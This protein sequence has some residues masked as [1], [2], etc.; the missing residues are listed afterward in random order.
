M[1]VKCHS[2]CIT[3]LEFFRPNSGSVSEGYGGWTSSSGH[4]VDG[5]AISE[6]MRWNDA[7]WLCMESG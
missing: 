7:G 5:E 4:T 1:G 3:H 6:K 2:N